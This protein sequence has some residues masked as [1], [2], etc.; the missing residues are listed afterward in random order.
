MKEESDGT[1]SVSQSPMHTCK[2]LY[3]LDLKKS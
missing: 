2:G 1:D 3:Y